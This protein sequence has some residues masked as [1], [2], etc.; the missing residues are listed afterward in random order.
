MKIIIID[1]YDS[2][3]YNLFQSVAELTGVVPD[4]FYNDTISWQQFERLKPD[5][6]IISPG[7]GDP[8]N[9]KDFGICKEI[10]LHT[11]V[12]LLGVCLGHQGIAEAF[13]GKISYAPEVMHGRTSKIFHT[14]KE[15]F[16][17]IPQGFDAVRYHSLMVADTDFPKSLIKTAWTDDGV[18]MG[19]QHV[20]RPLYGIQFHPES[21]GTSWGK[22][23]VANFLESVKK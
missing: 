13:G 22:T 18:I 16:H 5:A 8:K 6:V 3:T 19:L 12:P 1:N 4:V 14:E 15:L 17:T 10:I 21:I 23:L 7:P 9:K 2:F 11:T 20:E